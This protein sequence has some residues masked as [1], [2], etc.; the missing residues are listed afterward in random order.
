[1]EKKLLKD[2]D[3]RWISLFIPI[4]RVFKEYKSLTRYMYVN[5][6]IIDRAKDMLYYL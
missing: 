6:K 2:I 5:R 4:E 3:T 1:M